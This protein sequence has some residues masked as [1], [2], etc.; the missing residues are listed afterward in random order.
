MIKCEVYDQKSGEIAKALGRRISN[1]IF[2]WETWVTNNIISNN[3]YGIYMVSSN[4]SNIYPNNFINNKE[5]ICY[6]NRSPG[7]E[8]IFTIAGLLV[9]VYLMRRKK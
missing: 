4:S 3:D 5:N 9:V 2:K 1:F 8:T 7:F 6:E